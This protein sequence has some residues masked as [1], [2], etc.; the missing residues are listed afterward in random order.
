M[1]R[2]HRAA[3][4]A[5]AAYAAVG[6]CA[7]APP[8]R[9]PV[10]APPAS[11]GAMGEWLQAAPADALPRGAWWELYGEPA[12]DALEERLE[13]S[14]PDLAAAAARYA[15]ARALAAEANSGLFPLVG[16][17][18]F[19]TRNRQSDG[20]PLRSAA[21][22]AEY[23]DNVAAG[24]ASYEL[25]LWGRMRNLATIGRASAQ[26][27]AADLASV[28]LSLEA[29]L[30]GDYL[31]LRGLDLETSL[32]LDTVAAYQ[33]ALGLARSR[34]DGGIASG[35]DVARA[36]TQLH[37]AAAQLTDVAARRA[38]LEHAIARLV[39]EPA[40]G[41]AMP[42]AATLP[43]LPDIPVAVPSTLVE[44]RPDV[45][46]AERRTAAANAAIGVARAAYFPR[47]TLTAAGGFE[48][49]GAADWLSAPN[50]LWAVGPAAALTL[51]DAGARRAEVARARSALTEATE[52]YRATVLSAFQEVADDLALLELLRQERDEQQQAAIAAKRAL[53]LATNRY[54]E[55]AVNYL[56]VV[57]AQTA[58]LQADRAVL[59]LQVRRLTASVG[60]IRG[61]GGG[62]RAG[63]VP[64]SRDSAALMK[65]ET[66][67]G[68]GGR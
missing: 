21:Q 41:L 19:A 1:S 20:R 48:S 7:L 11:Y 50:R 15:E 10:V 33:K 67:T 59:S 58:A 62:W 47:L 66:G 68:T 42:A 28:R 38:L 25:D 23:R 3:L 36:E 22:P 16:A 51:F 63:D 52:H 34:H 26:A 4:P 32:L 18:A 49:S 56:D 27:S 61:L 46:A 8:Y 30:A 29:E 60:L 6:G 54:V 17:G 40:P 44:R 13:R 24:T 12:L 14:S 37:T 64:S 53:D 55:G 45:A 31:T 57:V 43:P 39:G 9:P 2:L 5:L 65:V 35:L